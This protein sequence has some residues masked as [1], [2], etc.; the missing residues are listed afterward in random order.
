MGNK[1]QMP[2]IFRARRLTKVPIVKILST[3][4]SINLPKSDTCPS[5][6]AIQPSNQSVRAPKRKRISAM[7]QVQGIGLPSQG[8]SKATTMTI[9]GIRDRVS[10]FGRFMERIGCLVLT[11]EVGNYNTRISLVVDLLEDYR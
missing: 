2:T 9:K 7:V 11:I 8:W 4:A 6:R 3:R 1:A 5:R 10:K